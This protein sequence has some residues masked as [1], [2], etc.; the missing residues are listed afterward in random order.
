MPNIGGVSCGVTHHGAIWSRR[1]LPSWQKENMLV[2]RVLQGKL[3]DPSSM[4]PKGEGS[5]DRC[6]DSSDVNS[7]SH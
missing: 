1:L 5:G 4:R 6:K 3:C 7:G 2:S